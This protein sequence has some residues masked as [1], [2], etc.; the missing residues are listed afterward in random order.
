[1]EVANSTEHV[2]SKFIKDEKEIIVLNLHKNKLKKFFSRIHVIY[3]VREDLDMR[4]PNNDKK[5]FNI[6]KRNILL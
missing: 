5:N 6:I 3:F 1:M 2:G 4:F